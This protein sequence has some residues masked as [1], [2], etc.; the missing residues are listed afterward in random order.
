MK[1]SFLA[2]AA[3]CVAAG[4][5]SAQNSVTLYGVLDEGVTYVN[6]VVGSDHQGH[7]LVALQSGVLQGSR[8][9]LK[10]A[11]DLGGGLKAIFQ[12]ES[13]FNINNGSSGQGGRLFGR[14]SFVGLSSDHWGT[15]TLG[16]QY[17]SVVDYV[18]PVTMNGN[19]GAMFSHAGD[20]DNSDNGFRIN[21]AVKYASPNLSGLEFGGLY[22]LGGESGNSTLSLGASYA[23]GPLYLG[24][25]YLYAKN[26]VQQFDDGNWTD[27][28]NDPFFGLL[29]EPSDMQVIGGG[30][31]YAFGPALLGA[32]YTNSRYRDSIGG[33]TA[34]FDNYELWGQ[35]QLTPAAVLVAGYTFTRV[36][37]DAVYGDSV[38]KYGQINLMADYALSKRTDVY[39]QG[40]WQRAY[41]SDPSTGQP[42]PA[43]IYTGS[44]GNI[45][46]TNNQ[47]SARLGIRT[48]F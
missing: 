21:N 33:A 42:M 26:P 17:D 16:R 9:G 29:G 40:I 10:G 13:G 28:G 36:H 43:S 30:G 45:S 23:R 46:S 11:E 15:L 12:L 32:N 6:N 18:Q 2:F 20:I 35:Y 25:G 27:F 37:Q 1:K 41:S 14:Q 5:A 38:P 3:G 39:V 22:A 34:R 44:P 48:K 8:W 4:S 24:A 19:W 7:S 47:V 31:T